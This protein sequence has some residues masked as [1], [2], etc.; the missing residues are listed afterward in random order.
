MK[1]TKFKSTR[2]ILVTGS[3]S[4]IGFKIAEELLKMGNN[5][6]ICARRKEILNSVLFEFKEKFGARVDGIQCDVSS[7]T[8]VEKMIQKLVG[9]FGGLD[10]LVN[11]AG[12]GFITPFEAISLEKWREIIDA[13]LN[14]V[15]NCCKAALPYL[16]KS[17]CAD[18]VNVGSR[19]GRYSFAGGVG[20]NTTKF[21]LQGFTEAL[22]LDLSKDGIRVSLVAPGVVGTGLGG[23]IPEEW[24]LS[25]THVAKAV[26][27][28]I[29]MDRGATLNWV[30]IRPSKNSSS[31]K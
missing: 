6:F 23:A 29:E 18:I 20:Y 22:F 8:S 30:E 26:I 7:F 31:N 27:N 13:N 3:S 16:K 12:I 28:M 5:V 25:P 2:N 11:N 21:G 17:T 24:H 14:G 1:P 4:G 10:I 9:N 15:F 19:S